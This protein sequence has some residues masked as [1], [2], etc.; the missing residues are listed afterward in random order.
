MSIDRLTYIFLGIQLNTTMCMSES[1]Q[2]YLAYSRCSLNSCWLPHRNRKIKFLRHLTKN[3][4]KIQ[5]CSVTA[6]FRSSAWSSLTAWARSSW[7]SASGT[8]KKNSFIGRLLRV[9]PLLPSVRC[10][11]NKLWQILAL[12]THQEAAKSAILACCPGKPCPGTNTSNSMGFWSRDSLSNAWKGMNKD[13]P[14]STVME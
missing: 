3:V 7:S 5:A 2:Q 13:V 1:A 11:P 8:L 9:S 6:R 12:S 4:L 14:F 10:C